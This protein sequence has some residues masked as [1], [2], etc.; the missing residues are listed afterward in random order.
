MLTSDMA[1]FFSIRPVPP[2]DVP[3]RHRK[4]APMPSAAPAFNIEDIARPGTVAQSAPSRQV[5]DFDRLR[6]I[7]T[8]QR[9]A[10]VRVNPTDLANAAIV[11]KTKQPDGW[12]IET[13]TS[14]GQLILESTTS[15]GGLDMAVRA[16]TN[17]ANDAA[18]LGN[19]AT[20]E[21]VQAR[22]GAEALLAQL[23][24]MS[25]QLN[26]AQI[27]AIDIA[28]GKLPLMDPDPTQNGLPVIALK[29][30]IRLE[31][32]RFK[33]WFNRI[34][35]LVEGKH[36]PIIGLDGGPIIFQS[37]LNSRADVVGLVSK[38][39]IENLDLINSNFLI[40]ELD[41]YSAKFLGRVPGTGEIIPPSTAVVSPAMATIIRD[42]VARGET[43]PEGLPER[44]LVIAG[45]GARLRAPTAIEEKEAEEEDT[46]E[47]DDPDTEGED[48][49]TPPP[50]GPIPGEEEDPLLLPGESFVGEFAGID[51]EAAA[52]GILSEEERDFPDTE[53]ES[54][55][56]RDF[57]A[58]EADEPAFAGLDDGRVPE[59]DMFED[60]LE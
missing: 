45:L 46:E 22:Q 19:A 30:E 18:R 50:P 6:S 17:L 57:F 48:L 20:A 27:L 43:D 28:K 41:M 21:A 9:G 44:A 5:A 14:I 36:K 35:P 42:A 25:D 7:E 23:L 11:I 53:E 13:T 26:A 8:A 1:D 32:A 15:A 51:A 4:S 60:M 39:V 37:F 52:L 10:L 58:E 40:Q 59:P 47:E 16:L 49:G 29:T 31:T 38:R 55:E 3:V 56:P 54:P 34:A 12:F 2:P 24:T 33:A